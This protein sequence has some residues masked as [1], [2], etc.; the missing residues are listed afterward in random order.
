M[1]GE[2]KRLK[3]IIVG[4]SCVGKSSLFWKYTDGEFLG[5]RE[6]TVTTID[7]KMKNVTYDNELIKL[8][9]WDTAGQ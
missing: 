8:Y 3:L 6:A 7:F 4:D 1:L 5:F 2:E 9:I